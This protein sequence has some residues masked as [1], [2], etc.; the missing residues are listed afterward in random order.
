MTWKIS[1]WSLKFHTFHIW[2]LFLKEFWVFRVSKLALD[3][4]ITR[5]TSVDQKILQA[6]GALFVHIDDTSSTPYISIHSF[7]KKKNLIFFRNIHLFVQYTSLDV[8]SFGQTLRSIF[9]AKTPLVFI[10]KLS[11]FFYI[12]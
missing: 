10:I 11:L 9:L 4:S 1:F 2:S 7:Y 3:F 5:D 12:L 6:D 8:I